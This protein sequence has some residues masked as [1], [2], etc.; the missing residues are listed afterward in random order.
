MSHSPFTRLAGLVILLAA[1]AVLVFNAALWTGVI[2][3]SW[4]YPG[5]FYLNIL[6]S[7]ALTGLYIRHLGKAGSLLHS[8]YALSAVSLFLTIGFT[9]YAA[10]AFPILQAQFPEA[11]GAVLSGPVNTTL[12][13]ALILGVIGN[14][15]FFVAV[16]RARELPRWTIMVLLASV[17][18]TVFMLP[19]NIP[20]I[21]AAVGLLG[22]GASMLANRR[23]TTPEGRFQ[24]A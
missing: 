1:A 6:L 3:R 12:V 13:A 18:A 21:V 16:F 10:F 7:F 11:V 22:S 8:G 19:Y 14:L 15:L 17:I 2:P 24:A 5:Y 9:F 23:G 20:V 4:E